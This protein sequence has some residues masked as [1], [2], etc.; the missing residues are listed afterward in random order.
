[1]CREDDWFQSS[2]S[3]TL[4]LL[5]EGGSIVYRLESRGISKAFPFASIDFSDHPPSSAR[6]PA[7]GTPD[8]P[9]E[10]GLFGRFIADL[11]ITI[12]GPVLTIAGDRKSEDVE[13]TDQSYFAERYHG[14]LQRR[15]YIPDDVDAAKFAWMMR[16]GVLEIRLPKDPENTVPSTIPVGVEKL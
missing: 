14:H 8:V 7:Q 2:L 11:E 3:D 4:G 6:Q 16:D 9:M 15:I 5:D 1:M 12:Q 10:G 13:S